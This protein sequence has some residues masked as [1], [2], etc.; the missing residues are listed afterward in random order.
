MFGTQV[1]LKLFH[2]VRVQWC[3]EHQSDQ[4]RSRLTSI[5][6]VTYNKL[7]QRVRVQDF[8][9][10]KSDHIRYIGNNLPISIMQVL[11]ALWNYN[12]LIKR[13]ITVIACISYKNSTV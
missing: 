12:L 8:L 3:L 10:I 9:A 2:C 4:T 7:G 5:Y 1:T 6:L 11:M 13:N